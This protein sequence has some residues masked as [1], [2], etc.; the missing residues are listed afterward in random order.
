MSFKYVVSFFQTSVSIFQLT[1]GLCDF[2]SRHPIS[3]AMYILGRLLLA[4]RH[5]LPQRLHTL[6]R[7]THLNV[8]KKLFPGEMS[9][10]VV[11]H[12]DVLD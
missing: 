8:S 2:W 7:S 5:R 4:V 9:Q 1:H 12:E 10:L 3:G 11:E 6:F